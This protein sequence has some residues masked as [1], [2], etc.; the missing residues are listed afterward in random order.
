MLMRKYVL[1]YQIGK[2]KINAPTWVG[3]TKM[4]GQ[5]GFNSIQ[6]TILTLKILAHKEIITL[7]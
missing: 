3:L 1:K 4:V 6:C 5:I 7:S 2:S